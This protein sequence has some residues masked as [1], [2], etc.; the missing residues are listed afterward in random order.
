MLRAVLADNQPILI[1]GNYQEAAVL[2][3]ITTNAYDVQHEPSLIL[4]RR[5]AHL[6]LHPGEAAFPGGK[7]DHED[8][9]LLAT[10]LREADEEIGLL[11]ANIEVLGALNQRLTRTEIKVSPFVALVPADV[12]LTPNLN[13]VDCIYKVPISFLSQQ[14]KIQVI[15]KEYKGCWERVPYFTYQG[16]TIWGVTALMIIDLMNTV[17]GAQLRVEI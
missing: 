17:F 6:N 9:S 13:E 2:I 1:D 15:E 7:K 11:A 5:A 14:K 8:K 4:T 3:A 16:E 10:A 12:H